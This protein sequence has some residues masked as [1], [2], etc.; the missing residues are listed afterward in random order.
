[1]MLERVIT[2]GQTGADQAG[3]RAARA[4]AI[5]TGGWMPMGFRTEGGALEDGSLGADE[6][7]PEFAEIYGARAL[8][9]L[10]YRQRTRANVRESDAVVWFG[11]TQSRGGLLTL[12]LARIVGIPALVVARGEDGRP[13]PPPEHLADWLRDEAVG[14][15]LVAGNRESHEPGI[16]ARGSEALSARGLPGCPVTLT[17]REAH[18]HL[19]RSDQRV[20]TTAPNPTRVPPRPSALVR[21]VRLGRCESHCP[22]REETHAM[23][24][25]LDRDASRG[26]TR[27]TLLGLVG[28][29]A[30][31]RA[32]Q[33]APGDTLAASA[34]AQGRLKLA[35]E[36]M[37]AVRANIAR[38]QFNPGERDPIYIWSRRRMEAR[39]DLS[40]TKADRVAAAQEHVDEMKAAE[41]LV[42]RVHAAGDVDRLV[43]M[44]AQYRRLEAESWLERE[45]ASKA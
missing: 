41:Q 42:E 25:F 28:L 39:I 13:S 40:A 10:E 14:N 45:K 29:F 36:G 21:Y 24:P 27:R 18:R 8:E 34:A 1:M 20:A 11:D 38:G 15:L 32:A 7:H 2:G 16:G 31:G 23:G 17:S 3:W 22:A 4:C 30:A 37:E 43:Q 5:A 19:I 33:A 6:T 26:A 44:D 12:G 35:R 9:S